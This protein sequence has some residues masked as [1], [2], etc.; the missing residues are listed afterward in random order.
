MN[1]KDCGS[2]EPQSF[3]NDQNDLL[4]F[5]WGHLLVEMWV[6]VPAQPVKSQ[7]VH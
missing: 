6:D 3:L 2:R 1:Q 4:V 7:I 5:E